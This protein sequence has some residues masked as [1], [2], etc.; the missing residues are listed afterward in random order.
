M[1]VRATP[2][3]PAAR[4]RPAAIVVMGVSG[5]GKTTIGSAVAVIGMGGVGLAVLMAARVRGAGELIAVVTILVIIAS[6]LH[7]RGIARR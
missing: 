4:T 7:K 6:L 1:D 5:S 3:D 2:I